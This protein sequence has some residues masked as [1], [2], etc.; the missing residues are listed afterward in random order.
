MEENNVIEFET[1]E[2]NEVTEIETNE[3]FSKGD[4]AVAV[5][6]AGLAAYGV[7]NLVKFG[8][9][10]AKE[11][12]GKIKAKLQDHQDDDFNDFIDDDNSEEG[13]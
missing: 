6:V 7:V 4:V 3:N 12:K 1:P 10:K 2:V 5:A 8:W 9:G 13:K 11:L